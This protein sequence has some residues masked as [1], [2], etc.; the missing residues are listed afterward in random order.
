MHHFTPRIVAQFSTNTHTHN[1]THTR[2]TQAVPPD[3]CSALFYACRDGRVAIAEYLL[4]KGTSRSIL[5]C[6]V[7]TSVGRPWGRADE[8]TNQSAITTAHDAGADPAQKNRYGTTLPMILATHAPSL[9]HHAHDDEEDE[10]G[11]EGEGEGYGV[12]AD[13]SPHA[14]VMRLL[15]RAV[16]GGP[17]ARA[18]LVDA[19]NRN[20]KTGGCGCV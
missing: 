12:V 16:E 20:G 5:A 11:G 15:L 14:Q 1:T 3:G 8:L 7:R 13:A 10:D 19:R 4:A 6:Y 2:S 18:A 17:A 9:P